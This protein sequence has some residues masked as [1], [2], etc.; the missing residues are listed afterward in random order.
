VLDE[1]LLRIL[2]CP[3]CRSPLT[4]KERRKVLICTGCAT[5]Y[6]VRDGIPILLPPAGPAPTDAPAGAASPG[7]DDAD[8]RHGLP[9]ADDAVAGGEPRA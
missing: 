1:R 2:V 3:A 9:D 4:Y 7:P 8:D 5:R 6:E